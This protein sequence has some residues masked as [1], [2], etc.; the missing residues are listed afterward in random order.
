MITDQFFKEIGENIAGC[1]KDYG[2]EINEAFLRTEDDKGLSISAGIKIIPGYEVPEADI[3]VSFTK[4]K[5]TIKKKVYS[6]N[7]SQLPLDFSGPDPTWTDDDLRTFYHCRY[8]AFGDLSTGF[9][10]YLKE[11]MPEVSYS[12]GSYYRGDKRMN[13]K[14]VGQ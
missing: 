11:N 8:M 10:K 2:K 12:G 6:S 4:E 7:G 3:T 13:Y 1:L 9:E 14:A 5:V